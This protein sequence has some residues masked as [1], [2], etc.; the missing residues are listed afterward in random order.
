MKRLSLYLL[1]FV[2]TGAVAVILA[3]MARRPSQDATTIVDDQTDGAF[4]DGLFLGRLDAE[5]G[6]KPHLISGR[7]ITDPD[8]RLFIA[9]YVEAYREMT[10]IAVSER[11]ESSAPAAKRGY[12]DG[13]ADGRQQRYDSGSFQPSATGNYRNANRGYSESGGDLNQ[14]KQAYRE[15]YCN[16]Y[17]RAYYAEPEQIETANVLERRG[18]EEQK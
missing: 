7:W 13:I 1:T 16:G 17:Q 9:A 6:R 15:A 11:L 18:P 10:G 14:Y 8:R 2:A 4:R 12:R 5:D 3:S